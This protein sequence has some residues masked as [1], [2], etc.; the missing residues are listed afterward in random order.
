MG[1]YLIRDRFESLSRFL[2]YILRHAPEEFGLVLDADGYVPLEKLLTETK[3]DERWRWVKKEDLLNLIASSPKR[4]FEIRDG[5]IRALYG[6][7]VTSAPHYKP[8]VPPEYL[9]HGTTRR[10]QD[11]IDRLGLLPMKRRFVHLSRNIDDAVKVGKRWDTNP[12][13]YRIS[14]RAAHKDGI[15]FFLAGDVYLSKLI[16]ARY[17]QRQGS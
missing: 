16:P 5:R 4:R 1:R 17:L 14:A 10:S 7:T 9:Y 8:V 11:S 3:A 12:V 15:Q 13:I 2:S 6:H